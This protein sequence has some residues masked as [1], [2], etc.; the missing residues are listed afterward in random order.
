MS[1]EVPKFGVPVTWIEVNWDE[2]KWVITAFEEYSSGNYS[3]R[4]L[5]KK[6]QDSGFLVRSRGS[7][8]LHASALEEILRN[9][10]Y[11]G[12]IAWAGHEIPNAKHEL[13]LDKGLFDRVQA[14]MDARFRDSSR[15]VRLFSVLKSI[16][17]CEECG[18][19]MTVEEHKTSTGRVIQYLRC[20]KA[21]KNNKISCSQGYGH[22][23]DYLEQ[24]GGVLQKIQLPLAT[25][26]KVR[27]KIKSIFNDEQSVYE[28]ARSTLLAKIDNIQR[29]KKNLTIQL[30]DNDAPSEMDLKHYREVK[31]EFEE[32]ETALQK[33]LVK[34]QSRISQV[35]RTVE[36]AVGLAVNCAEAFK[37]ASEPTLQALLA[38]TLIK[39]IHIRDKQIK[40]V[41]LNEPLDYLLQKRLQ[42]YPVFDLRPVCGP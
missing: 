20:I 16:S 42:R 12:T 13:F 22:E 3:C 26:E 4:D 35:V 11:I 40:R 27:A 23:K 1:T 34:T 14:L 31:A 25:T 32:E 30:A 15:N 17:F 10:F 18:S 19:K 24:F 8:R 28:K 29:K 6:L 37:M 21:K 5:A 38:R 39:E 7:G 36:V 33:D 9:K 41:V 2:A